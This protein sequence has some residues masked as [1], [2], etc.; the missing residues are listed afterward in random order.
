MNMQYVR[1]LYAKKMPEEWGGD[2]LKCDKNNKNLVLLSDSVQKLNSFMTENGV[3]HVLAEDVF[4]TEKP[5]DNF[6]FLTKGRMFFQEQMETVPGD[7][8]KHST[9]VFVEDEN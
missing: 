7:W 9:N 4:I 5:S 6:W 2:W 3:D 8:D 1:G